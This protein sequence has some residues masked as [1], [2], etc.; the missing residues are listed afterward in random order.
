MR[1]ALEHRKPVR[2]E[3]IQYEKND[4]LLNLSGLRIGITASAPE[5]LHTVHL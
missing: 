2:Y 4:S 1:Q 5:S 3:M